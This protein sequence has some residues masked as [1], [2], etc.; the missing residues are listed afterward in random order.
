LYFIKPVTKV[1]VE[2]I[3][4]KILETDLIKY[5]SDESLVAET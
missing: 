5:N 3:L 2:S 1:L 4:T